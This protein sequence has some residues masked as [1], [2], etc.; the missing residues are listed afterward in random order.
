MNII[1]KQLV[2]SL[3]FLFGPACIAHHDSYDHT[4]YVTH[5]VKNDLPDSVLVKFERNNKEYILPPSEI[6]YQIYSYYEP[7]ISE[8]AGFVI[9]DSLEE[10]VCV[11]SRLL[12]NYFSKINFVFDTISYPQNVSIRVNDDE[13][14]LYSDTFFINDSNFINGHTWTV[15]NRHR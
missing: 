12:K 13:T 9:A 10:T 7:S 2:A 1:K 6:F 8:M 3:C 5:C 4:F 11:T 15:M 14:Y